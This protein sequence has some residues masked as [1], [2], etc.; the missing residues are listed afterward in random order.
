MTQQQCFKCDMRD[1]FIYCRWNAM[2]ISDL[3]YEDENF[4]EHCDYKTEE[5]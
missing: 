3:Q 4:F 5:D 2:F 1:E